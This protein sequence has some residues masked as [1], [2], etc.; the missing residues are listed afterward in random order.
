MSLKGGSIY[1]E[2]GQF[3]RHYGWTGGPNI[4]GAL[5]PGSKYPGGSSIL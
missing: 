4:L 5:D 2:G 1:P 3:M